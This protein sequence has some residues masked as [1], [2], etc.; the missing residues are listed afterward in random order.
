MDRFYVAGAFLAVVALATG[1]GG[2]A[3]S[4]GTSARVS[5]PIVAPPARF[6][7]ERPSFARRKFGSFEKTLAFAGPIQHVVVIY[8]ENRTVDDLFS[9]YFGVK[10]PYKNTTWGATLDLRDPKAS[11]TLQPNPIGA[12]FDPNHG[13]KDAFVLEASGAYDKVGLGCNFKSGPACPSGAT[14]LSYVPI[15]ESSPYLAFLSNFAFANHV[16]QSNEGPSFPAHQYAIAGQSGG[17]PEAYATPMY[18]PYAEVENP[19]SPPKKP[20][21]RDYDEQSGDAL[22]GNCFSTGTLVATLDMLDPYPGKTGDRHPPCAEYPTILDSIA[23]AFGPPAVGDWQYIAAERDGIWAAPMA[24]NHLYSAYANAQNKAQQPFAID[25][26]AV[27]FVN[28]LQTPALARRPFASVTYITPC[29]RE[30]DHPITNGTSDGPAWL[31]YVVNAIGTSP[32]W[33][34]TTI[35]VTWDDWGGFYDHYQPGNPFPFR[36]YPNPYPVHGHP[37]G[38]PDDPN[39]WG[40]R[41]PLI[42]ISPYVK[43]RGYVSAGLRSQGAILN[44]IESTFDLPSLGGDDATNGSDNLGDMFDFT[45]KAPGLAFVPVT[46]GSVFNPKK[47]SCEGG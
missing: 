11:P 46:G 8:M 44:Y 39:E 25:P 32:Y 6:Y 45:R 5:T 43:K 38:N 47:L 15:P 36:P 22:V 7:G 20:G 2:S 30:S 3:A 33:Q 14:P 34:N 23:T 29:L 4:D 21:F 17:I 1:L 18:A 12:Y 42:V 40:F 37:Q 10:V 27:A 16:L 19:T 35:L 41:V 24:V 9:G 28:D 31:T 13:H 26:D